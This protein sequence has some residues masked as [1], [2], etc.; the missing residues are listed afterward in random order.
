MANSHYRTTSP[1]GEKAKIK[2]DP[3]VKWINDNWDKWESHWSGKMSE[4]DGYYDQWIGK[5]PVRAEEWQANFNKKL[6]WQAE[7]TLVS[8]FHSALFPNSAPL[9]VDGTEPVDEMQGILAKSIVAHWFK[10]GKFSKEFLSGMRSS[11]IYGTGLFEDDWYQ[12]VELKPEFSEVEEDDLRP[13]VDNESKAITD[14]KGNVKTYK[15][16]V[17][18]VTR[19][20]ERYRIVEDRY[21]VKKGN[22]FAWRFHPDKL[23][24]DDDFGAMKVEYITFDT[25]LTRQTE[26][27]KM[28]FS[29]FD[30]MDKIKED[31][32]SVKEEDTKRLQKDGGFI[33]EDDPK[34]QVIHYYGLYPDDKDKDEDGEPR[35]KPMWL[36]AV[37]RKFLLRKRPNP[38]W[39][40]KP[41]VFRIVW[42]E[43]ERPSYYGIGLAQIGKEAELRANENVNIRTD[44]K[45]KLVKGRTF[46]KR[47]DKKIK[48]SELS[49]NYPGQYIGCEDV[50][51]FKPEVVQPLSPD[52]Y[53][54]E[55]TA[56][57]DFREITGA[58]AS[59]S[60]V[61][62]IS[63][64]HK[65]KGGMQLLLSQAVQK[66]KPDLLMM[67]MM[68]IRRMAN[69]G[70]LLTMQYFSEPKM[71]KL[72][73]SQDQ[74]KRLRLREMYFLTPDEIKQNVNFIC[75]GISENAEKQEKIEQLVNFMG[76][77]A[78]I[79]P[80]QAI[81]NYQGIG[82]QIALY[83]GFENIE[84]LINMGEGDPLAPSP[85]QGM[86]QGM[87]PGGPQ[88]PQGGPSM[89]QGMPQGQ[90]LIQGG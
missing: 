77:S 22:I 84:D 17:K 20:V 43:D 51:N 36:T 60:P 12:K 54:E 75:T 52:D 87:G 10:I 40:K 78:K 28:G 13:M 34:L 85:V 29:P 59:L 73:A 62:D 64:Q 38:F 25:L 61:N 55:E 50:N 1:K 15:V 16:G 5:P 56:V 48:K 37:N 71:I 30:N 35:K 6:T 45:K 3:N 7:K 76:I 42:T 83:L 69:R 32:S 23:N 18:K 63:Q 90:P 44:I 80:L 66:L 57:N 58:T 88:G 53:K 8:R 82:K 24:D 67:E 39:H 41:P 86:P 2:L 79:L 65:T 74:K 70:F 47:T 49:K 27:V 46:Y 81:T 14:E 21:R 72:M 4:F 19:E 26:A 89:P 68:G 11:A 9:D 33:D 31:M